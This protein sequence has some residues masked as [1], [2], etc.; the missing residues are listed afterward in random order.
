MADCVCSSINAV[1]QTLVTVVFSPISYVVIH[2]C[3]LMRTRTSVCISHLLHM[4]S[5]CQTP[6]ICQKVKV[7]SCH[8][9]REVAWSAGRQYDT[10]THM[11]QIYF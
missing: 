11:Y 7:F 3:L 6:R 1:F 10:A 8:L 5:F 9:G 2:S 4:Q